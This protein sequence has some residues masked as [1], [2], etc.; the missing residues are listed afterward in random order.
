MYEEKQEQ[1]NY[2]NNAAIMLRSQLPFQMRLENIF[3]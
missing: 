2:K 1:K 3:S